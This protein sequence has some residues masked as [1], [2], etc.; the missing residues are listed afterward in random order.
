MHSVLLLGKGRGRQL[1]YSYTLT[2]E[3]SKEGTKIIF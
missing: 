2:L 3:Q 1:Q